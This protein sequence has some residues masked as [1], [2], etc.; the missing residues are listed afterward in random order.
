M[1]PAPTAWRPP[2]PRAVVKAD[3][4]PAVSILST[5]SLFGL[6]IGWLWSRLAP[7]IRQ[8]ITPEGTPANLIDESYHSFD[9]L[10]IFMLLCLAAGLVTGVAVWY[11]RER[12]GP[13]VMLAAVIGGGIAGWLAQLLGTTWAAA[14]WPVPTSVEAL[15][16]VDKAPELVTVWG[17]LA[18]PMMT[19]LAYGVLATVNSRD[20]L[21]R[22]LG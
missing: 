6:V 16:I 18:W 19:A 9:A 17:I 15:D 11:L 22:R 5:V 13:V 12:R 1:F 21:G 2:V 20:D 10:V 7:P 3:L 4:L 8:V 14:R